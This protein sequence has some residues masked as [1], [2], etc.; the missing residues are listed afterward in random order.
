MLSF[1]VSTLSKFFVEEAICTESSFY[2]KMETQILDCANKCDGDGIKCVTFTF[3]Y[4][5]DWHPW[6]Y[7]HSTPCVAKKGVNSYIYTKG[8]SVM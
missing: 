7:L 6:C 2:G 8:R 5:K 1:S 4:D 3:Y